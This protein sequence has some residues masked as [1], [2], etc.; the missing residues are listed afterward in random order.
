LVNEAG[1]VIEV[2]GDHRYANY[3]GT[4]VFANAGL[5]RKVSG[6]STT[7][8]DGGIA[9][10][11]TGLFELQSG[12]MSFPDGYVQTAGQTLL[13]GGNLAA[14]QPIV[15]Q[16]GTLAG[17]GTVTGPVT[18]AGEV[19]PG[20][21]PGTLTINGNYTQ[22]SA[23]ILTLE[24]EGVDAVAFDHLA[25]SGTAALDGGLKTILS[26]AFQP[27]TNTVFPFLQAG[28]L[29][30][31][32][33][34]HEYPT[35]QLDLR[36]NY[37]AS[38]AALE[39][40]QVFTNVSR[41]PPEL[42]A[43]ADQTVNELSLLQLTI[44]AT[45]ADVP[46][47]IL[48]F[49]LDAAPEGAAIHP[50]T[51]LFT[52][53]PTEAQGPG[54]YTNTVRVIDNGGL[55]DTKSFKVTV[56]EVNQAPQLNPVAQQVIGAGLTLRF[57]A[58][59]T[60]AD[61]PAQKLAFD[62]AAGVLPGMTIN[63]ASGEFT[64]VVPASQAAGT[65]N[66]TVRVS[67]DG[68]PPLSASLA[69][70]ITVDRDGPRLVSMTPSGALSNAVDRVD[71]TF[72]KAING[73]TFD[74]SDVVL[75][76]PSGA[77]A[78]SVQATGTNTFRLNFITLA[79]GD[80]T[81]QV[82][83][84]ITDLA[85]N[86]MNQDGDATNG[87]PTQDVFTGQ[88]NLRLPDLQV[89]S[90][91]APAEALIGQPISLVWTV[92]NRGNATAIAPWTDLIKL[93][94]KNPPGGEWGLAWPLSTNGLAPGA[95]LTQTQTV[96][97]PG[98][99]FGERV[100]VVQ[101][102]VYNQVPEGPNENNN[103][104]EDDQT[105]RILAPDLVVSA[106]NA[107]ANAQFGQAVSVAWTVQNAGTGQAIA[108]WTDGVYLSPRTNSLA[109]AMLLAT[110]SVADISP[111]AVLAAYA[112][113]QT[114]TLP[115]STALAPGTYY[116]VV[117]ADAQGAQPESSDD[118]NLASRPLTLSLPPLPDLLVRDIVAPA[119]AQPG[120][121]F[122][123][124]WTVTN[125]GTLTATGP[126]SETLS[127][128]NSPPLAVFTATNPIGPGGFLVRTQAFTLP[129]NGPAGT[130]YAQVAVD[131]AFDVLEADET[132]NLAVAATPTA[133]PAI[134]TLALADAEVAEDAPGGRTQATVTRNGDPANALLVSLTSSDLTEITVPATVSIPAGQVTA[135]FDLTVLH[136]GIVDG[137]QP[138]QLRAQAP[139]YTDAA[140]SLTVQ[141]V[142]R[143]QLSVAFARTNIVE[144]TNVALTLSR[145]WV[146]SDAVTV[147]LTSSSA[148]EL[149]VPASATIPPNQA[150]VQLNAQAADDTELNSPRTFTVSA[151]APGHVPGSA[152]I[153]V[154]DN[155][156]PQLTV[157]LAVA[158][159]SEGAGP[160]ATTGTAT[161]DRISPR[162]LVVT[163]ES[164]NPNAARVPASVT[165]PAGALSA[166][167]AVA[168]INNELVDGTKTTAIRGYAREAATGAVLAASPPAILTVLDD[169]GP[170][171]RLQLA[172]DVVAEAL[173]PATI[174]TVTRNVIT[175]APLV[176]TLASSDLTEATVPA[177][178]TI[179][180][181]QDSAT[182]PVASADDGVTDGDQT[183]TLTASA[184][185]F[186]SGSTRLVV[187]DRNLPDLVVASV[188][189]PASATTDTTVGVPF[190][191]LNQGLAPAT[192]TVQQRVFLSSDLQ[193]G[194]DTLL[195][196][197]EFSGAVPAGSAF[198]QTVNL[199]LPKTPGNYWVVVSTD[200]AG[201]VTETLENN[202]TTV[203]AQPIQV[204][205]AY[206]A[207]VQADLEVAPAGTDVPL[208]GR[209]TLTGSTEPAVFVPVNVQIVVRG[210]R[211]VLTVTTDKDGLF[212]TMFHPLPG[213]AGRYDIAADH[214][215][216]SA[217]PTQ[218]TFTLL[219]LR[220]T[221]PAGV[222]TVVEGG[223]LS[224]AVQ[225]ENL[226]DIPLTGL[227]AT[228]A[229]KPANLQV[230]LAVT[231][232]LAG[233][234][235]AALDFTLTPS[236]TS[237][238]YGLVR[239]HLSTAEGI[240]AEAV[241]PVVIEL[242]RP[243]LVSEP[244]SLFASMTRGG[245]TSIEFKLTNTG[246]APSGDLDVMP[247]ALPWLQ[248][249]SGAHLPSLAPG[250]STLVTLLLTPPADLV[251]ADHGG[252]IVIANTQVSLTLPFTF[253][254][255]STGI[256]AL[257][258]TAVDEY[259]YYAQGAPHPTNATVTLT[260]E[261]SGRL[262]ATG[263]TDARGEL[264]LTNLTEAYYRLDVQADGHG[265]HRSTFLLAAG[266]TN[267]VVA[268]L[269]RQ[270][271]KYTFTVVPTE[272]EDRTTIEIETT[273]E[274]VVPI[275]LITVEPM[276]IDLSDFQGDEQQIDLKFTNHGL[277]AAENT[278]LQFPEHPNFSVTPLVSQ[279]G[280]LPAKS[281]ITVPVI[282]RRLAAG[283]GA[284]SAVDDL[285]QP[286]AVSDAPACTIKGDALWDLICGPVTRGNGVPII[287][288]G[289]AGNC[290]SA[291]GGHSDFAG[292][293]GFAGFSFGNLP[294]IDIPTGGGSSSYTGEWKGYTGLCS[295]C[296][297]SVASC[298]LR[299]LSSAPI[300]CL[301]EMIAF[302]KAQWG[303]EAAYRAGRALL[304][305]LEAAGIGPAV[306]FKY[307]DC[308][309]EI[310]TDC[311]FGKLSSAS[312]GLVSLRQGTVR[313]GARH[314]VRAATSSHPEL[315]PLLVQNARLR[316]QAD[317]MQFLIGDRI[318]L[319][320]ES[321]TVAPWL[322]AFRERI[323]ETSAEGRRLSATERA[324]LLAR[325]L[326]TGVPESAAEKLID[327]WNRTMNYWDAGWLA[328]ADVPASESKDFIAL[329]VLDTKTD[330]ASLAIAQC[331]AEGYTSVD[332]AVQDTLQIAV[333]FYQQ[334]SSA[335]GECA[336]VRLKIEQQAVIARD[337]F[338]AGLEVQNATSG[339]LENVS[340]ELVAFDDAGA[341]AT[342]LFAI[343]PPTLQG[344]SAVDGTGVINPNSTGKAHWLIIPTADA[345]PVAE[346]VFLVSGT[347]SYVQGGVPVSV[348]LAPATITV[349]PNASLK[350]KYF[351]QR[352][353]FSDDPFTP[354]IE[355]AIPFSLAVLIQNNGHGTARNVR[356]SSAQPEIIENEKG[357]LI[358]FAILG[359]EIGGQPATPSL[360]AAF[361]DIAPGR[362]ALGRWLLRSSLQGLFTDYKA[363]FTH[364]DGLGDPRLSLI[365]SVE[366]HE[367][368]HVVRA[369][370][371]F[372]DGL[373]DFLVNDVPDLY[374]QPDT[375]YLSDGRVLPVSLVKTASPDAPP[376]P[377]HLDVQLTAIM[378]AGWTYLHVP[379][380]ADGK[381]TL[382]R[383]VRSDGT[384]VPLGDNAWI[385]DRTFLG[386]AQRPIRE[387]VLHLLDYNSPGTY[388]LTYGTP[389]P[390]DSTAP[391]S[392]VAA[393]PANSYAQIPVRWSGEDETGGSGIDFFDVL[394][395]ING[396]PFATWL[397]Q[398]TL[399]G[400]L[401][402]GTANNTYAFYCVA[403][404][405]AGNREAAHTTPDALTTVNLVNQP[406]VLVV[407]ARVTV[408][409]GDTLSLT[410]AA[411]D[412]D[413]PANALTFSLESGAPTGAIIDAQT[414][415]LTWA[416]GEETGPSTNRITVR[417]T[418]NGA[419]PLSATGS[420]EVICLEVNQPPWLAPVADATIN[421][422]RLLSFLALAA[423]A[424]IP[425]NTLTFRLAPGAPAGAAIKATG[426]FTWT[427]TSVQ[428]PS[429]NLLSIIVTDNGS[430]TLSAT[431]TFTVYVRDVLGDFVLSLGA[432][433]ALTGRPGTLPIVLSSALELTNVTFL[434]ET[435]TPPLTNLTVKPAIPE[436]TFASVQQVAANLS[437]IQ[438]L[439]AAGQVLQGN[440][441][442]AQ[443]EF[444]TLTAL[445][446]ARVPLRVTGLSGSRPAGP[447]LTNGTTRDGEIIIIATE[448]VL[449]TLPL[450][451]RT[452]A[453]FGRPGATYQID[454]RP[455][456]DSA[457]PW[458]AVTRLPL[459][460]TLQLISLPRTSAATVFYRATEFT[461][462]PAI[463][464]LTKSAPPAISMSL[465][466]YG[467][468]GV[469][470]EL[471]SASGL[472]VPAGWTPEFSFS[473]TNSFRYLAPTNTGGPARF[474]RTR[475]Q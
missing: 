454:S 267:D 400:A 205:K 285:V 230:D 64:W 411:T 281:S 373:P 58:T 206:G 182:F 314:Q 2:Q 450:P 29:T 317:F 261:A 190:R 260:D 322:G 388:T 55:F 443:L 329:D 15:I 342:S 91:T 358:D 432:T 469:T 301:K 94:N 434:L 100:V 399:S 357:L 164:S 218:D 84:D 181:S 451:A 310:A 154:Q 396:G 165:I 49:R 173:S 257:K 198:D 85:G 9:I 223:S 52:W 273:F 360:T 117:A 456:L 437:R 375:L 151:T 460:N 18:N 194:D 421:E 438:L 10:E 304:K 97:L 90:I 259:T 286:L 297:A 374:D 426:L 427:P 340:V 106:L 136:D 155:D 465:L 402:A 377:G 307:V 452:L 148:L 387:N 95:A 219:G 446:S 139:A 110:T 428:G 361:G 352:D 169:D 227:T 216:V 36:V 363:S 13:N 284:M 244:A 195:A 203:A 127:F 247:P 274:T 118:N 354:E 288:T 152:S 251:L 405:R 232:R 431:Q 159:V 98:G 300:S 334:N 196:Q 208:R 54:T 362:L 318:W 61:R 128:S 67:D 180:A 414:G 355:P 68:P 41:F 401:Y 298:A 246:G 448:P 120:Q 160:T 42:G 144:G 140:A 382:T 88:L 243:R 48:T 348:P 470:Y 78:T 282:I 337:A 277:V 210:T 372:A 26:R 461:T 366:I 262:V 24:L 133:V 202:N 233:S 179:L 93:V 468:P 51:G 276:L 147:Q 303:A 192:G 174:A 338:D 250:A 122:E 346:R 270:T 278:R 217:P 21:S 272:I 193:V 293:A 225:L 444:A 25:V 384:E 101:T 393:L 112:R 394:V 212:A 28:K 263:L 291:G 333:R 23:G 474:F 70:T 442:V 111:L 14:G 168:A 381:F 186:T 184:P 369:G 1:G 255:L 104:T 404:D 178:V 279:L 59:A 332:Q 367:L 92:T 422:G 290:G 435:L 343:R 410:N 436:I 289:A 283:P 365:D 4:P 378:P 319:E 292:F 397:R 320:D 429:T 44:T 351:H 462:Q 124:R 158:E 312:A 324:E 157:A 43:I 99:V 17:S 228:V 209:A 176:V 321:G 256:G 156:T 16:G 472:A 458:S 299:F 57:T 50:D 265:P 108:A 177:N 311:L 189:P 105:L 296:A 39:V 335:G 408:A 425:P 103:T 191:V 130:L 33:A 146:T 413:V 211:R 60:D 327:R 109:D 121:S 80:Y 368:I 40:L 141:D 231:N 370:G 430:P 453:L 309:E 295:P 269:P 463:L 258:V 445:H 237:A 391:A 207:V 271:V 392:R 46:T 145:D 371:T 395:S 167:F 166:S 150:S 161:R 305:C 19:S 12:T 73:A 75:T 171:L 226:S 65:Y 66:V 315:D 86:R 132:N 464:E 201:A 76:G 37:T 440:Q 266:I 74:A 330:A 83:P 123:L 412:P 72:N 439:A 294:P 221:P 200:T 242:L 69:V 63:S 114:V 433:N 376:A 385:T 134:L 356:I 102:D 441:T 11:N 345:A 424:D 339:P 417:V 473:L 8:F 268:F 7:S 188:S 241:L 234:A 350:V 187:T 341:F 27:P 31:Q 457:S 449:E 143:P 119:N 331:E 418:D 137:P 62:L 126:W 175:S 415:V 53:T 316:S 323:E 407:P 45:D 115:L 336:T 113:T 248:V 38:S 172:R 82:G 81:L 116:L 229:D 349:L 56:N 386:N 326:P 249:A 238:R 224:G 3:G 252:T 416:T 379:D 254:T 302:R 347:L 275:P 466:L 264:V 447:P 471:Q 215:G 222:L 34:R 475:E 253:R 235:Q 419:P 236:D 390:V 420:V 353:V 423:D 142:D 213:E 364:V 380:P 47:N 220:V 96:I 245:Q 129:R 239:L 162:P 467:K 89:A 135:A 30:G 240:T 403:T 308:A 138:V 409:E 87:E 183:V 455:R 406:P 359:S 313:L 153:Q 197:V 328:L 398:T 280:R 71:L 22:T 77:L 287:L 389:P 306:P 20:T 6:G 199:R 35:N 204:Q 459:T 325:P 214:P 5:F 170:T 383:V 107:P 125:Q 131:T 149:L 185:G 32:F 79:A 163:L 344:L